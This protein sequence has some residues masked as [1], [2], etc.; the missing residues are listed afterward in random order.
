M[1]VDTAS[2]LNLRHF[3]NLFQA[4]LPCRLRLGLQNCPLHFGT[5][6]LPLHGA[7]ERGFL[8]RPGFSQ[9]L[10]VCNQNISFPDSLTRNQCTSEEYSWQELSDQSGGT[11]TS[12]RAE[13]RKTFNHC[14]ERNDRSIQIGSCK[15][16]VPS[17]SKC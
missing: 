13:I 3:M 17:A 8:T 1:Q 12:P 11:L 10:N 14:S 5:L 9:I 6:L 4:I 15:V 2:E 7:F 16:F